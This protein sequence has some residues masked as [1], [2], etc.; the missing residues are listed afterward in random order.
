MLVEEGIFDGQVVDLPIAY[1]LR[2]KGDQLLLRDGGVVCCVVVT[3]AVRKGKVEH[4]LGQIVHVDSRNTIPTSPVDGQGLFLLQS[5][6]EEGKEH[7]LAH[8]IN[9][10]TPNHAASDR[11]V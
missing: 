2:D 6:L 3:C 9:Q 10:S 8:T 11:R 5:L 1:G 4:I 7:I